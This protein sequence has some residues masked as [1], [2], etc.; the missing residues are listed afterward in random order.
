MSKEV[1]KEFIKHIEDEAAGY[2]HIGLVVQQ[3]PE[4]KAMKAWAEEKPD[5]DSWIKWEGGDQP[6]VD[7]LLLVFTSLKYASIAF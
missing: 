4:Y 6:K 1:V 3:M 5:K 2:Q 7:L